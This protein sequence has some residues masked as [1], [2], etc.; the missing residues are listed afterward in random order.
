[1]LYSLKDDFVTIAYSTNNNDIIIWK[2]GEQI[3]R[4]QSLISDINFEHNKL[5]P[6]FMNGELLRKQSFSDIRKKVNKTL[7]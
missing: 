2:N 1:M 4:D 5:E 3:K 7:G 6:V